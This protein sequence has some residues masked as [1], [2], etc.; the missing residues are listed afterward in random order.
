MHKLHVFN[1]M[2]TASCT[3]RRIHGWSEFSCVVTLPIPL[4][5]DNEFIPDT[6]SMSYGHCS[7]SSL[8]YLWFV[9]F[10]YF[11]ALEGTESSAKF[12]STWSSTG[13]TLIMYCL[14]TG[15]AMISSTMSFIN[16]Y[17]QYSIRGLKV[18]LCIIFVQPPLI[19]YEFRLKLYL[20]YANLILLGLTFT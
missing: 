20:L 6:C 10:R 8:I 14:S 12:M 5:L 4:A 13:G 17:F 9:F 11:S 7:S 16:I 3:G 15:N 18:V 19:W 1:S 2:F